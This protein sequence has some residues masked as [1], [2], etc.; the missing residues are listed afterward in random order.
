MKPSI[1]LTTAAALIMLCATSSLAA[2]GGRN[3]FSWYFGGSGGVLI[4]ETPLQ[5]RG[6]IPMAGANL[7]ITAK[8]TALMI[9]VEEGFGS[10]EQ[11]SY[12][13]A[14]APGGAR[15]VTF[16]DIRKYSFLLMAYPLRSHAQPF[17]GVGFGVMHLHN[18]QPQNTLTPDELAAAR[19]TATTLG[20]HGFGSAVAGLQL[21]VGG[22][23]LYGMYQ[24][25]TGPDNGKLLTGPTHSLTAGLRF[26]LGSAKEGITGGGY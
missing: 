16:N 14:T 12:V 10:D 6:G 19:D 7:L 2:Q 3:P 25:T 23:A 17:I 26:S 20:S 18:P 21:Q 8:R 11:T 15:N 24:F 4:F 5:E 1:R 13:D 22:F 9:S